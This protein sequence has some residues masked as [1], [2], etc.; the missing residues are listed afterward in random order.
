MILSKHHPAERERF[1]TLR[2]PVLVPSLSE[3]SPP[4]IALR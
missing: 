2:E 4:A 1:G 3:R